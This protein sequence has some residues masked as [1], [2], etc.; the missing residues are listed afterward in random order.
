MTPYSTWNHPYEPDPRFGKRVAYLCMEFGIHQPLKIFSGGLGFL[1]GSHMRSAHELRQNL[2]GVG[3][4]WKFGYYDQV[5]NDDRT[6]RPQFLKKYY[7]FLEETGIMVPVYI[8]QHQVLVKALYLRP[9]VFGTVPMYLLTTNI[10][11]NDHLGRSITDR[12]YDANHETRV[13]QNII[14]GMGG[15]KVIEALGGADVYHLNEGHALPLAFHLYGKYR[16]I[17]EVRRRMVF[18]THTPEKAGNDEHD[19]HLLNRLGFFGDVPLDEVR[20]LTQQHGGALSYTPAC[21]TFSKRANGV[22]QLHGEV[23]RDMWK[24]VHESCEILGITNAQNKKYWANPVLDRAFQDNDDQA[25]LA[26]KR[27]MKKALMEFVADQTGKIFDPDVLTIVWARRFAAYKRA[28]L[29]MRDLTRFNTLLSKTDRPI[30]IIWAGKPYPSDEGAISTFNHIQKYTY[31]RKNCAVL[32]GYEM[33]LS[34]LLKEGADVWLNTP[35][36]PREAS[37][38]SGMTAAMNGAVNFSIDD[39]WI[40]EFARHGENCFLIPA[41]DTELQL[42]QVDDLDHG[43]MMRILEQELIPAYYSGNGRWLEIVKNS[44][45]DVCPQFDSDRMAT[46]YYELLYDFD[47]DKQARGPKVAKKGKAVTA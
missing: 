19:F 10:E 16:D 22:S 8:N 35:R 11:E 47:M 20:Q 3:M 46:E 25:M 30:Q 9:E 34:K 13:V 33:G 28:D 14:L 17:N 5:R 37:G 15:A 27:I 32:T 43:N 45:R 18:T 42:T 40:P 38:T 24:D 26:Q 7:P 2:I 12:L 21:L 41:A 23:S 1:A 39:G 36:R 4:L 31:K 29:I 44:M 6:M